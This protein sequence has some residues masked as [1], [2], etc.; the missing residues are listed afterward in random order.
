M[1]SWKLGVDLNIKDNLLDSIT[2]EDAITALHCNEKVVNEKTAR[3]VINEMLDANLANMRELIE[4][5]I[6]EI[7]KRAL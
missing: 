2:F 1:R 3:K 7:V 6:G 5:N 4:V